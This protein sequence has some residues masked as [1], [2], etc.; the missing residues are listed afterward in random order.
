MFKSSENYFFAGSRSGSS[1]RIWRENPEEK[2]PNRTNSEVY[3]VHAILPCNHMHQRAIHPSN[4]PSR[5][6]LE[7]S[8]QKARH[9]SVIAMRK[10]DFRAVARLTN[11]AAQINRSIIELDGDFFA[12]HSDRNAIVSKR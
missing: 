10:G 6:A 1:L 4:R 8:L 7:E 5:A 3:A 9:E 12:D 11:E 2:R